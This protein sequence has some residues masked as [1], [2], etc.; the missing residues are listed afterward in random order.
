MLKLVSM[1]LMEF[2]KCG[3]LFGFKLV[4]DIVKKQTTTADQSLKFLYA[5]HTH[6]HIL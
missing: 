4:I 2:F 5:P 1:I 6:T 3:S